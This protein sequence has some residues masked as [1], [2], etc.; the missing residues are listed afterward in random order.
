M[1]NFGWTYSENKIV[2]G[3]VRHNV[4]LAV[5]MSELGHIGSSRSEEAVKHRASW[6]AHK[7]GVKHTGWWPAWGDKPTPVP[8]AAPVEAV[9]AVAK[10][11]KPK[12]HRNGE[13]DGMWK[14]KSE[15]KPKQPRKVPAPKMDVVD[16]P[17]KR[18]AKAAV[19]APNA[20]KAVIIDRRADKATV[21]HAEA[22]FAVEAV[23][24]APFSKREAE[25]LRA[26][27][28]IWGAG[29]VLDHLVDE[30]YYRSLGEIEG[31]AKRI[32]LHR[33]Y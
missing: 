5:V 11:S 31:E 6:L 20:P 4:P 30:G 23:A 32:G 18:A 13:F 10:V 1:D 7:A 25:I 19:L 28:R 17:R 8:P 24:G 33:T 15:A 9:Q 14:P 12:R 29:S 21:R 27:Y 16:K 26:Y 2:E 3:A 22:N